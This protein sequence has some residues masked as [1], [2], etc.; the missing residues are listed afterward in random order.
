MVISKGDTMQMQGQT[1]GQKSNNKKKK[2]TNK[3]TNNIEQERNGKTVG[4]ARE[5]SN[6]AEIF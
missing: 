5:D 4:I 2:Q 6:L 1:K 3:Q